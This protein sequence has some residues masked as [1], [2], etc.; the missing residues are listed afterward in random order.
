M[1]KNRKL[2]RRYAQALVESYTSDSELARLR[3]EIDYLAALYIKDESFR[4]LVTHPKI[5]KQTRVEVIRQALKD[6][7]NSKLLNSLCIITENGRIVELVN[8]RKIVLQLIDKRQNIHTIDLRTAHKADPKQFEG[9]R[10]QMEK[11]LG[12]KVKFHFI[13]D[14]AIIGGFVLSTD[15]L[16][17]DN[18]LRTKYKTLERELKL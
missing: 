13:I 6:K 12:G 8:L 14:P 1:N 2:I 5:N 18:S 16:L 17:Y 4:S 15:S 9:I 7:I 3:K 11:K 10:Q